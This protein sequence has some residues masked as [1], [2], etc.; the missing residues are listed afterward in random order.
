MH[1][2]VQWDASFQA[3]VASTSVQWSKC[4]T[5]PPSG[6]PHIMHQRNHI[7]VNQSSDA[8]NG[9]LE[10]TAAWDSSVFSSNSIVTANSMNK[11]LM[12][13]ILCV[14]CVLLFLRK[15]SSPWLCLEKLSVRTSSL[16]FTKFWICVCVV[17]K[18]QPNSQLLY[19]MIGELFL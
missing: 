3:K 10:E 1:S 4:S 12:Y 8:T 16:T 18:R 5:L 19:K 17:W 9:F 2:H 14:V 15:T 6:W 13:M 7:S 11:A